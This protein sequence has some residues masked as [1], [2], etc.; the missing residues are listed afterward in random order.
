MR[1][2]KHMG[3]GSWIVYGILRGLCWL[4]GVLPTWFL[5]HC[6]S[7]VLYFFIY[8][9]AGYRLGVTRG[10][11]A[12]AFPEKSAGERRRIEKLFYRHLSE[13]M[14]DSLDLISITPKQVRKRLVIENLAEHE[15][16][17][18]GMNWIAALAHYGSWEYFS[19]YP[20]YTDSHTAS[21]YRPLNNRAVDRLMLHARSRF[22]MRLVRM[23][24]LGRFAAEIK[25]RPDGNYA[26]G[27]VMDQSPSGHS[28]HVWVRFLGQPTRFF[29][30]MERFAVRYGM[31]VCFFHMEKTSRAHYRGHFE[32]IYD[33]REKVAGGEIVARYAS[34]LERQVRE[35]PELWMWSHRRWKGTVPPE[36]SGAMDE[37]QKVV[38]PENLSKNS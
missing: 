16:S 2:S 7:D 10:N 21:A 4:V 32:V 12:L 30:S 1:H 34:R 37:G 27:M 24:D 23:Y 29:S 14:I 5:Y 20:L 33:G 28:S 26:L 22:G 31:K 9:V 17:V 11:L 36:V 15:A 18:G 35:R 3:G 19:A 6:L 25:E 38:M 8:K 13:V